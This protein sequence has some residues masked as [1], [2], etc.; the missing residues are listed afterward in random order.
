MDL[1]G[2]DERKAQRQIKAHLPAENRARA[3]A[4]AIGLAGA[5]GAHIAQELKV[6]SHYAV[7][8]VLPEGTRR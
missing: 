2:R 6:R 7:A 4:G 5:R 1:L 3:R 8:V